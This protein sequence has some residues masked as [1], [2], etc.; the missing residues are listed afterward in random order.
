LS[1]ALSLE[2]LTEDEGSGWGL[3]MTHG[4]ADKEGDVMARPPTVG[5]SRRSLS[6]LTYAVASSNRSK[7][8]TTLLSSKPCGGSR[9][10]VQEFKA[11]PAV[12]DCPIT[13]CSEAWAGSVQANG[14]RKA[15]VEGQERKCSILSPKIR[16][17]ETSPGFD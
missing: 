17:P 12:P 2:T 16:L 10:K 4:G 6:S 15:L 3:A 7:R 8:S 14:A 9:F 13:S 1:T 11:V 5:I